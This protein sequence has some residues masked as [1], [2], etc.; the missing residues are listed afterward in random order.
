MRQW[1]NERL[2]LDRLSSKYLKKVFPVHSTYFFG[3]IALFSFVILVITGI[4]LL[5]TYE[6]SARV[7]AIGAKKLPIA[8]SS[9]M[10]IN[11]EP[12]GMIIRYVHHWAAHLM[13]AS[14][15]LH[16]AR[17]YFTGSFKRPR[18]INWII[19]VI[20]LGL[21]VFA[22]FTGYLLPFDAFSTTATGIGYEI[23]N[24]IPFIG[25]GIANFVFA[26]TFPSIGTI[27]RFFGYH[28]VII[29]MIFFA[30]I[31]V[32][33]LIMVKQKH[34]QPKENKAITGGTKI[35]GIPLFPQQ[36][37]LMLFLFL[38]IS[39][40]LFL[41]ASIL[42][43]HPSQF[44]GPP[45]LVTPQV[46]PDW[47]FLWIFG[48]LKLIPGYL[49]IPLTKTAAIDPE[50]IGGIIIPSLIIL[51]ILA[52][53]FLSKSKKRVDYMEP[54]SERPIGTALGVA[55]I[56]FFIT[57]SVMSYQASLDISIPLARILA[58][59]LPIASFFITLLFVRKSRGIKKDA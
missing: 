16:M 55:F 3:E 56:V 10:G 53:P 54:A 12:L 43:V 40:V 18:E 15:I 48:I 46:K 37:S 7:V 8:Y 44:F 57:L 9:I 29:P 27:P 58:F 1:L 26:G 41:M 39:S 23:A 6:P 4:Y 38:I 52:V 50:V 21:T 22:S 31:G 51:F 17:I 25:H 20:L 36:A 2:D 35:L 33:L 14:L 34:T 24:S 11:A 13:I 30:V 45:T 5:F 59:A 47:Y 42:P 28:V 32:H 19:G 49:T